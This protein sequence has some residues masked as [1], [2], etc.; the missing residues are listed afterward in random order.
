MA[1]DGI[2]IAAVTHELSEKLIN[3]R[4]DKIHQ[5]ENDEIVLAIRSRGAN[6]RLLL[7]A[8]ASFARAHLVMGA[9]QKE[10]PLTAP[11]FCMLLRKHLQGGRIVDI[12]QPD[13]ERI[14]H[15]VVENFDEMGEVVQKTLVM[16]IMGKYSNIILTDGKTVLDSIKHVSYGQSSVRQILP[17][18]P[19]TVPPSQDKQNPLALDEQSFTSICNENE[20]LAA[21]KLVMHNYAGI[22]PLSAIIICQIAQIAPD[23]PLPQPKQKTLFVTFADTMKNVQNGVF[24]PFVIL[25][26]NTIPEK[27]AVIGRGTYGDEFVQ[28]FAMPSELAEFYF[29]AKDTGEAL[30]QKSQDMRRHVQTLIERAAK[31]AQ[32]HEATLAD[33]E[34]REILR[35][36]GELITAGIYAISM[37][38]KVYNAQNFYE[39]DMPIIAIPL[40][41]TKTA[42]ENAQ[43]YF[44]KYNKQ[45]RTFVALQQQM[46][47][48]MEEL[49]YL[50]GVREAIGNSS[51]EADLTQIREELAEQGFIK[52][53]ETKKKKGKEKKAKPLQYISSDGYEILVGKNNAQNDELTLRIAAQDDIWLHTK[54]IPGSHVILRAQNGKVTDTALEEAAM[55][56]AY[57]SR[58]RGGSLV[59]VDYCPRRQ[60]KKP[61]GAKPGFVIYEG[62]KTA[63]ITTDE[64]KI[65]AMQKGD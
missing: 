18:R 47:Q 35:L 17:G 5:P 13:F 1:Y 53:R 16:E 49:Q 41:P 52:R 31:K 48:N 59:P 14:I 61:S 21:S 58:A 44:A 51:E 56:A 24:Q 34:D 2:M 19:Y 62:H 4:I 43:K 46:T 25:N 7:C 12:K 32:M 8:N 64:G 15:I 40:D 33:I 6:H 3:G 30:R 65:N 37:G 9:A 45:K 23:Q 26:H 38:D 54:N 28:D 57:Y 60:V 22:G 39:E 55:L 11:M 42:S 29:A 63:Y 50:E 36:Y 10:N 20:S 27:F